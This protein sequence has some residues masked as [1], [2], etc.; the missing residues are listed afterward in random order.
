MEHRL[1]KANTDLFNCRRKYQTEKMMI[2]NFYKPFFVA[3]LCFGIDVFPKSDHSY[4]TLK[5]ISMIVNA[6]LAL[7]TI[8]LGIKSFLNL[9][10]EF[11]FCFITLSGIFFKCV[12]FKKRKLIFDI[13]MNLNKNEHV[14]KCIPSIFAIRKKVIGMILGVVFLH[15]VWSIITILHL[16]ENAIISTE[17]S[18]SSIL[19]K[20][21]VSNIENIIYAEFI[22]TLYIPSYFAA[23]P[24]NVFFILYSVIAWQL[25]IALD[26][27]RQHI[28]SDMS[29]FNHIFIEY[30]RLYR[31]VQEV[32]ELFSFLILYAIIFMSGILY[33][34]IY[35][36]LSS[37]NS[38]NLLNILALLLVLF[39][40]C[41]LFAMIYVA[42]GIPDVNA[43]IHELI[44]NM[45][46]DSLS[47]NDKMFLVIKTQKELG[48]SVG[49]QVIIKKGFFMTLIGTI[50]TYLLLTKSFF[51]K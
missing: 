33:F 25:T 31:L 37:W 4:C 16:K 21:N 30:N 7:A 41:E 49:N 3:F 1:Q 2:Y 29:T 20:Y 15:T 6:I 18:I 14:I 26:Y 11:A 27:F 48:L 46:H 8:I 24:L 19:K 34:D 38:T 28:K 47:A 22:I 35:H 17:M 42:A 12:L 39:F 10:T 40:L 45:S 44:L 5:K 23:H 51:S 13:V 9:N 50:F 36:L 32:N 43:K